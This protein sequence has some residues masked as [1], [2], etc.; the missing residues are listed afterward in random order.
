MAEGLG[1]LI[2]QVVQSHDLRGISIHGTSAI[3]HQQFVDDNMLFRHPSINEARTYKA[4]LDTL[5]KASG[6]T[7]NTSKSQIFFF[8]TPIAT[9][10]IIT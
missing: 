8:H 4:L 2:M 7:I 10:R 9:Q 1:R 3:T 5:S 6:T